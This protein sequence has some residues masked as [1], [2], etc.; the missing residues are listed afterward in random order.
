MG[1]RLDLTGR[2][3][4][5]LTAVCVT[6]RRNSQGGV[7][8]EC[9]CDCGN[10]TYAAAHDLTN[11]NTRSCGCSRKT[12]RPWRRKYGSIGVGSRLYRIWRNIKT[13]CT[14]D[15]NEYRYSRYGGRGISMCKQ[16]FD[17]FAAFRDWA[18]ANG[19]NDSLTID[20]IDNDGNYEPGNCRWATVSEQAYNRH[21]KGETQCQKP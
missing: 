1:A 21:K 19:Y 20:R 17:D 8:W 12:E 18:L 10:K 16:W 4:G 14:N 9:V 13:R 11:G 15:H 2:K 7:I 3:F 6:D 5:K